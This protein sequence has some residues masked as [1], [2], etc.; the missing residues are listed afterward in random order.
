MPIKRTSKVL[1]VH[2]TRSE[3]VALSYVAH[4]R[5]CNVVEALFGT[6]VSCVGTARFRSD[7]VLQHIHLTDCTH[8]V[9]GGQPSRACLTRPDWLPHFFLFQMLGVDSYCHTVELIIE[10]NDQ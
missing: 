6:S 9:A 1:D 3:H 10:L 4:R 5:N 7:S 2:H 8:S